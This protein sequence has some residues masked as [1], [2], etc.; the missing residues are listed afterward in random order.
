MMNFGGLLEKYKNI[1]H[2]TRIFDSMLEK[3]NLIIKILLYHI[4]KVIYTLM[5]KSGTFIF[6]V[7]LK[8]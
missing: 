4:F 5:T 7:Y 8:A 3:M 6:I 2:R 1:S